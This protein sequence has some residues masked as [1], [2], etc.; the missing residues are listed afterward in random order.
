MTE[1][2]RLLF[3]YAKGAPPPKAEAI[4]IG[5]CLALT[6]T[7]ITIAHIAVPEPGG[8]PM[9]V[10]IHWRGVGW[11]VSYS[12]ADGRRLLEDDKPLQQW[13]IDAIKEPQ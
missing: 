12:K 4:M 10:T 3:I 6:D 7:Y 1:L 13:V 5:W 8:A 9:N 11:I 2:G